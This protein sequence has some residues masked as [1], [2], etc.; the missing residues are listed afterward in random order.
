MSRRAVLLL[1]VAITGGVGNVN[2]FGMFRF[3]A[4][5]R[6]NASPDWGLGSR[7]RSRSCA[8]MLDFNNVFASDWLSDFHGRF[9]HNC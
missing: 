7:G 9:Y 1:P 4:D 6:R 8:T 5:S 2:A 3:I